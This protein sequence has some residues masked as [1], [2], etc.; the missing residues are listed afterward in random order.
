AASDDFKRQTTDDVFL[1]SC[2][3]V[4]KE[5]EANHETRSCWWLRTPGAAE[6]SISLLYKDKTLMDDGYEVANTI[7]TVKPA[8]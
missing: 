7:I 2:D 1:L 5:Y 6:N 4:A 8:I 3:G